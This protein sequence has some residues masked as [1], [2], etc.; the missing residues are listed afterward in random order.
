MGA[1][2]SA[3]YSDTQISTIARE[4]FVTASLEKPFLVDMFEGNTVTRRNHALDE[5]TVVSAKSSPIHLSTIHSWIHENRSHYGSEHQNQQN[6]T[7]HR[8]AGCNVELPKC[9]TENPKHEHVAKIM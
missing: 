2:T 3:N 4:F 9:M 8:E 5:Q 6:I 1:T 7:G